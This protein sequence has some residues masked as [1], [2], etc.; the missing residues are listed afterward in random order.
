MH[1]I[2]CSGAAGGPRG[3]AYLCYELL[4]TR[5]QCAKPLIWPHDAN[6]AF[7]HLATTGH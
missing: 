1:F 4:F 2:S 6:V 7:S 3:A 5:G